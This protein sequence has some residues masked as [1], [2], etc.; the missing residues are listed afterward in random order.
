[1]TKEFALEFAKDWID[2]WNSHD[3][4]RILEQ[5]SEN[6]SIESPMVLRIVPESNGFISGKEN[7]KAYWKIGLERNPKLK[8]ELIDVLVGI[9]R[10]T[11]Y[12]NN[13]AAN[14]KSVEMMR[15]NNENKVDEV[16]VNYSE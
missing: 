16:I 2:S 4:E 13:S 14:R 9:N 7:I 6:F 3:L 12:Y 11:L 8:F 1:M 5:Y 15:F 10:L